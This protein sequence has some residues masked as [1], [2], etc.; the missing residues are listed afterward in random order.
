VVI[1][2][3]RDIGV[4]QIAQSVAQRHDVDDLCRKAGTAAAF[5]SLVEISGMGQTGLKSHSL[6]VS[7]M[8]ADRIWESG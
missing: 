6:F 3:T 8:K 7:A 1:A 4:M 2:G 5:E